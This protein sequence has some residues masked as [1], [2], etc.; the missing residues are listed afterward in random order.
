MGCSQGESR[1]LQEPLPWR[2]DDITRSIDSLLRGA[3]YLEV[4][5]VVSQDESNTLAISSAFAALTDVI[6]EW[7]ATSRMT[8]T[9]GIKPALQKAVPGGFN[10]ADLGFRDFREFLEAGEKAG[11]LKLQQLPNRHWV[12]LLPGETLAAAIGVEAT[13]ARPSSSP[14][15]LT[16]EGQHLRSDVWSAFVDW[17]ASYRRQWDRQVRRAFVYPVGSTGKPS[18]ETEPSRF[19][20]IEP[21]DQAIQ[22]EWMREWATTLP[23]REQGIILQ[24][25]REDSPRGEFR[26]QLNTLGLLAA[27]RAELQ[28]RVAQ[29]VNDWASRHEIELS[30]LIEHRPRSGSQERAVAHPKPSAGSHAD[31]GPSTSADIVRLRVT[32]HRVIDT[33]PLA[34][35]AALQIPA[36]YLLLDT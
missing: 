23:P 20:E 27:W 3:I 24:A 22:T 31:S 32:L 28:R 8:T 11:Y 34:E 29:R 13:P 30:E 21:A 4:H 9:A 7:R 5:V 25:L 15:D 19:A 1:R 16:A 10:E 17:Q 35:L 26:R 36:Q 18:W 12:V 33:M 14:D 6:R 2:A